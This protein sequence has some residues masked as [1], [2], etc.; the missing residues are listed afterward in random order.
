MRCGPPVHLHCS[1]WGGKW[2]ERERELLR[3]L[4]RLPAAEVIRPL[5]TK[6]RLGAQHWEHSNAKT[7]PA[8]VKLK[9]GQ[10]IC[11]VSHSWQ[12]LPVSLGK[13]LQA[14]WYYVTLV[15]AEGVTDGHM[16][17]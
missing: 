15:T 7:D 3:K 16:S 13:G 12:I 2:G 11:P 17:D 8:L 4:I 14:H 6:G 5:L 10:G 9:V 1:L